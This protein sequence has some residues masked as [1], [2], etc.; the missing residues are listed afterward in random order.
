MVDLRLTAPTPSAKFFKADAKAEGDCVVIGGFEADM[1]CNDLKLCRWFSVRLTPANA[2]WAFE[3]HNEAYRAIASLE[4]FGTLMCVMLF[5]CV[6]ESKKATTIQFPGVTDNQGNEAL[7]HK[8]MSSK[9]PLYIVLL[10]LTEQLI[11]RRIELELV[12]Q[13]RDSNKAADAL[14]NEEFDQFSLEHRIEVDIASMKWLVLTSILKEA[15]EL[16]RTIK[17]RKDTLKRSVV[18]PPA[19]KRFK[20]KAEKLKLKEPW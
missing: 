5:T 20:R 6:N 7:M 9:F 14:T 16:H 1:S 12:W 19:L 18:K 10:E 17:T 8:N 13:A 11:A 4:L 15:I 2:S 3:K